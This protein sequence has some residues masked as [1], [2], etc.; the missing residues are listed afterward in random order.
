MFDFEYSKSIMKKWYT[1]FP[2]KALAM[3]IL[4]ILNDNPDGL[5][6]YSIVKKMKEKFGPIATPSPGT[7]YP[8]LGRLLEKG[9]IT[10]K[11]DIYRITPDGQQKV[12]EHIPEVITSLKFMPS[13]YRELM[14]PLSRDK[15]MNY[16]PNL[17][18]FAMHS[19]FSPLDALF[20]PEECQ[21]TSDLSESVSRLQ[22]IKEALLMAKT[23][24]QKRTD[25]QLKAIDD[26]I[27]QIDVKIKECRE[28]KESRVKIPIE[29]GDAKPE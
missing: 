15:R 20:F 17:P 11:D 16:F 24:I 6:G 7:I 18:F 12:T 10:E 3:V 14:R 8:R 5:N 28:E 2:H 25:D 23:E 19:G 21:C 26:Q 9:Y 4:S 22:E 29:D 13:L 27:Q 1:M